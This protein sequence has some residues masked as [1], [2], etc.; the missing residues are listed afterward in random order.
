MNHENTLAGGGNKDEARSSSVIEA[1][2]YNPRKAELTVTFVSGK[3]YAYEHVPDAVYA[4][5]SGAQSKGRFFNARIR[6]RYAMRRLTP[7]R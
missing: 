7:K 4:G 1:F 6:D 3:R 2:S 5:L